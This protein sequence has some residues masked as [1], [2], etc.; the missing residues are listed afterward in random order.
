MLG[1]TGSEPKLIFPALAGFYASVSDLWYPLIRISMGGFWLYHGWTKLMSGPVPVVA[2]MARVGIQPNAAA[3]YTVIF[4]ETVGALA[5]I[6]GL[7]TRVFAIAIEMAVIAF[8]AQLPN[9]FGRM[10]LFCL[11]GIV[12]IAIALRRRPLLARSRDRQEI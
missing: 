3:A 7:F 2:T 11:G 9:G 6:F 8:V 1:R 12:M 5:I 4:L 10:E